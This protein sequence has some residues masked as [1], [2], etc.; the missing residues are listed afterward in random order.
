MLPPWRSGGIVD[1][2]AGLGGHAEL[3]AERRDR[4]CGCRARTPRGRPR[5]EARDLQVAGRGSRRPA[6]RSRGSR[7]SSPSPRGAKSSRSIWSVSPGSAPSTA[8]GPLTWSTRSKSSVASVAVVES[9]VSSPFEASRQSNST[10]SP[11]PT[12]PPAGSPGPRRGGSARARRGRSA[13]GA[14]WVALCQ[15]SQ[16]SREGYDANEWTLIGS[17]SGSTTAP[18]RTTPRCSMRR[19]AS[20]WIACTRSRAGWPRGPG[21]HRGDG[22]DDGPRAARDRHRARARRGGRAGHARAGQRG[23]RHQRQG[24]HQLLAAGLV[25][26]RRA[27]R[28]GGAHR[29]PNRL[30]QRR[31][32]RRPVC[33]P[34]PLRGRCADAI[35]RVGHRRHRPWWRRDRG[36][37]GHPRGVRHGRRVR[38]RPD[39]HRGAPGRRPGDADLQLREPRRRGELRVA[40]RDRAQPPPLLAD[41]VSPTIRWQPFR[42]SRRQRSCGRTA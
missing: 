6:A 18:P 8:T 27:G 14:T 42:S 31:Q 17:S 15:T 29:S 35:Q 33:P 41:P 9:A 28:A 21:R 39:L 11:E 1:Q 2:R 24:C 38:A 30:Q 37:S 3:A 10:T 13:S 4:A 32:C 36:G 40:H 16:P 25:G 19:A 20:W 23:R 22:G 12:S 34:R 5:A 26:L 7:P